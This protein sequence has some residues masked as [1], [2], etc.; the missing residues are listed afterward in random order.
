MSAALGTLF[1]SPMLAMAMIHELSHPPKTYMESLMTLSIPA[2]I[3]FAVYY[4]LTDYTYLQHLSSA[5]ENIGQKWTKDGGYKPWMIAT[6]ML[7][8]LVSSCL[9][10][11][12]LLSIGNRSVID[13]G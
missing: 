1:P 11:F 5:T 6:A 9:C 10:F 2:C 13:P 12:I 7:I 8:G 3:A 4:G